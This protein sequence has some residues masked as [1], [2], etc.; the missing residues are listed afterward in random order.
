M[1]DTAWGDGHHYDLKI[2]DDD[3]VFDEFGEPVWIDGRPSIAQDVAHSIRESLLPVELIG[4]RDALE[5]RGIHQLI[6]MR[7]EEDLR[8]MPGSCRVTEEHAEKPLWVMARTNEYKNI[9]F[10]L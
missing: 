8:I 4:Q 3:L 5:R 2:I 10:Y 1:M 7:V 6:E 9:G